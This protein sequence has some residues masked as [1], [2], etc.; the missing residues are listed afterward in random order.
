MNADFDLRELPARLDEM[1]ALAASGRE[2]VLRDGLVP[3]ARLLP[4][5]SPAARIP[6]PTP[7]H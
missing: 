3:R 6:G 2:V 5:V 7:A 1:L 4:I